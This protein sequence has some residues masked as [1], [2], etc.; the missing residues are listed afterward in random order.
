MDENKFIG[1]LPLITSN[2]AEMISENENISED[3]AISRLYNSKLYAMLERENTK[4]WQFGA[5]KLFELY[6]EEQETGTIDFPEY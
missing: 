4:V 1:L 6:C 5:T 3:E 2:L